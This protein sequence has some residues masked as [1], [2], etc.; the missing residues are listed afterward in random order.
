MVPKNVIFRYAA[1]MLAAGMLATA[2]CASM[3]RDGAS[4]PDGSAGGGLFGLKMPSFSSNRYA[5]TFTILC[6]EVHG[7][8]ARRIVEQ[9]A[10]GLR[11]TQGL[12]PDLVQT[13]HEPGTSRLYYGAYRGQ[14]NEASDQFRPPPQ[15]RQELALL[16]DMVNG[17]MQP[18]RLAMIVEKPTPN[19]GP[20]EW[21]L[22]NAPGKYTLQITYCFDKP[23]LPNHK[24]VAVDICKALRDQGEEAWY[25]HPDERR[26]VVTVGRFDESAV[27]TGPD[28]T[29]RYSPAV[30]ALQNKR[31]EFKYNSECMRKVYR[32]IGGQ[33]LAAPSVLIEIPRES[34]NV[35]PAREPLRSGAN[36]FRY[37]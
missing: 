1:A 21:D 23:G 22:R 34:T 35:Q 4:S 17:S 11:H 14:P 29:A 33:R 8:S 16:R 20:P 9:W 24:Q 31:E 27:L 36:P 15:A 18:F 32:V 3:N 12:R 25:Y 10:S 28:G 7:D 5:T 6:M 30:V 13:Q 37:R 19:P 26:S 2:G